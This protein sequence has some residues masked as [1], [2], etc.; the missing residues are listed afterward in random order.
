MVIDLRLLGRLTRGGHSTV[1]RCGAY[2]SWT[3]VA[4]AATCK[5]RRASSTLLTPDSCSDAF[6][7][8]VVVGGAFNREL[9]LFRCDKW[10]CIQTVSFLSPVT[11]CL[12]SA[13]IDQSARYLIM[14]DIRRKALY[15]LE[16]DSIDND[17][18]KLFKSVQEFVLT[19]SL[20]SFDINTIVTTTTPGETRRISID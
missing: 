16:L 20:L 5:T 12:L 4:L 19:Q 17:K 18:T 6:W 8:H 2:Y 7:C 14:S 9:K 15:V 13:H 11:P 3:T 10:D 1:R